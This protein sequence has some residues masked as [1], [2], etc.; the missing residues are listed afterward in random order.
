MGNFTEASE[1][2]VT[3]DDEDPEVFSVFVTWLYFDKFTTEVDDTP[4]ALSPGLQLYLFAE[5]RIVR[6][7]Q[8]AIIDQL[9]QGSHHNLEND[10]GHHVPESRMLSPEDANACKSAYENTDED[11]KLRLFLVDYCFLTKDLKANFEGDLAANY[12]LALITSMLFRAEQSCLSG[13]SLEEDLY[14]MYDNRCS[15]YHVHDKGDGKCKRLRIK[16]LDEAEDE[17]QG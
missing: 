3:L 9:I 10:D 4:L 12:P 14:A 16:G 2:V 1:G 8:N 11:S 6:G 7:L 5:K 17:D 13:P 15:A